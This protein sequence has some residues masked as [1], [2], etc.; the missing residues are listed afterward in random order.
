M[1]V[2]PLFMKSMSKLKDVNSLLKYFSAHI[3]T[4]KMLKKNEPVVL[5]AGSPVGQRM[6]LVEVVNLK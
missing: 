5:V 1:G 4:V 2:V 3:K 6:N